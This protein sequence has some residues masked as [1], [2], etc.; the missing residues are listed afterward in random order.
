[1]ENDNNIGTMDKNRRR[2]R[3]LVITF[4]LVA[5]AGFGLIILRN[6]SSSAPLVENTVEEEQVEL[7]SDMEQLIFRI[8]NCSRLYTTEY[9]IHKIITHEDETQLN[10]VG[11]KLSLPF[12]D[13]HIAI[14][15][16]ATLKAYVD[17]GAFGPGNIQT[18]G[19]YIQIIL[20]DPHVEV[21]STLVDHDQTK[22][23]N[24]I[25][26]SKYTAK[27]Q[28][29]LYRQGLNSI[30]RNIL[31][32]QIL[33]NARISAA[34]TLIPLITRMGYKEENIRISFSKEAFDQADLSRLVDGNVFKIEPKKE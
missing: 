21:T 22:S 26:S 31:D 1:M 9:Q 5:L 8:Q 30:A 15:M 20:P 2:E 28:E 12:T 34:R 17:L 18:D 19:E 25:F 33:E 13:R 23:H 32:S 6:C 3:A 7:G 16:D 4:I 11:L 14:P 24:S 27:E 29:A 10:M